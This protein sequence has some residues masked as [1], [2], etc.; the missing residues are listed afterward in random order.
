MSSHRE[1]PQ[2]S[3]DPTADSTDVH[4]FVSPD[5]AWSCPTPSTC[6]SAHS[7]SRGTRLKLDGSGVKN[8]VSGIPKSNGGRDRLNCDYR[9]WK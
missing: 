7:G 6:R 1:A 8:M 3:K 4:A 9:T 2:I 5:E